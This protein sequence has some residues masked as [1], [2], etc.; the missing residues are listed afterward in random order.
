MSASGRTG[1]ASSAGYFKEHSAL[2]GRFRS[3]H[4]FGIVSAIF[5]LVLGLGMPPASSTPILR[6]SSGDKIEV[7]RPVPPNDPRQWW[8]EAF[9][10]VRAE[11]ERRAASLGP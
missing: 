9:R 10:R 11:T 2:R 8:L 6:F 1:L 7:L 5:F 4:R 3:L